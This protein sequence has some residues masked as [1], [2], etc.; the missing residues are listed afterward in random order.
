MLFSSI[1]PI[2][3]FNFAQLKLQQNNV[4]RS[5]AVYHNMTLD[6]DLKRLN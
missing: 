3:V 2:T 5:M 1:P 6:I 4:F